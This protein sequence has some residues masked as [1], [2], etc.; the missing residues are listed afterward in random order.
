MAPSTSQA[1]FTSKFNCQL[2]TTLQEKGLFCQLNQRLV[3][4]ENQES[5][6][7]Q[8]QTAKEARKRESINIDSFDKRRVQ[9]IVR[10]LFVQYLIMFATDR[11]ES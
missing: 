10:Q 8:A 6:S 1:N 4:W 7:I 9:S 5:L 2:Q 3:I 11:T